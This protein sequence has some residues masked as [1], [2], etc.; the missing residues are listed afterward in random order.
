MSK[1]K[2]VKEEIKVK[3]DKGIYKT[4]RKPNTATFHWWKTFI[5][6]KDDQYIVLPSVQC[7][8]CFYR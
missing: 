4:C 2:K 3:L 6:I 7:V 5:R 8:T 1:C